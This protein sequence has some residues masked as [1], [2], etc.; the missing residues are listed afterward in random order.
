MSHFGHTE[1]YIIEE[2]PG[3]NEEKGTGKEELKEAKE[4]WKRKCLEN[5]MKKKDIKKRQRR[6]EKNKRKVKS[7]RQRPQRWPH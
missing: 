5:A 7:K 1:V 4:E 3:H 6:N 2:V